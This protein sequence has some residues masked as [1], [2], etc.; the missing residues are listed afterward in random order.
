[1]AFVQEAE[2][3]VIDR[4]EGADNERT[5][6]VGQLGE[7]LGVAQEVLD[8]DS[9]IEAETG[10]ALVHP[11]HD[12]AGMARGVEEVGVG[13]TDVTGPGRHQL[14]DVGQDDLLRHGTDAP[15]VDDRDRAVPT[16]VRAA[17]AGGHRTDKPQL[18]GDS[19]VGVAA[20]LGEQSTLGHPG[21]KTAQLD[22]GARG[23]ATGPRHYPGLELTGDDGVSRRAQRQIPR[24]PRVEAEE[25]QGQLG[26]R[27]RTAPATRRAS[28]MA[29]CIGTDRATP[30]AQ[31]TS[32]AESVPTARSTQ[33]TWWPAASRRPVTVAT[34]NGWW[35]SS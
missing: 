10:V 7:H 13:E 14:V 5:A 12:P 21:L 30:S 4:F 9:G 33:R 32:S 16:T 29:V 28:R 17:P 8:L 20:Q 22:G 2:G 3:A 25:A 31:S 24:H 1:M 23:G 6:G 35:P 18:T 26:R 27:A 15:G 19:Q 34:D 11:G